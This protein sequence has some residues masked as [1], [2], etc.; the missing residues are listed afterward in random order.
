MQT[1]QPRRPRRTATQTL[2]TVLLGEDVMSWLDRQHRELGS[3]DAATTA[4]AEATR[5]QVTVTERTVLN[6]LSAYRAKTAA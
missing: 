6:W 5:G 3:W 1:N 4:L 2:A